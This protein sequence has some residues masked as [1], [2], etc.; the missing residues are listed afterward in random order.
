MEPKS[1]SATALAVAEL[2]MARYKAEHIERT[3]GIANSAASLGS[4]VHGALELFVQEYMKTGV[5]PDIKFLLDMF[6]ISYMTTFGT[7][8]VD[9][10]DFAE[11]EAML[12]A[13]FKRTDWE[14]VTVLSCEVKENFPI[15]TPIGKIP[16]N[17]IWDRFDQLGPAEY[18]VVDYK[19]NKWGIN[20]GDL[21]KKIQARAYGLAAQIKYPQ[22]ERIWVE[23]DMLRHEGPVGIVFTKE[24]NAATWRFLKEKAL[25]IVNTPDNE[26]VE[27]LNPE[28]LFCVRKQTC[29]AVTKNIYV[30]GIMSVGG[31]SEAVDLRATLEYQAKAVA[32][33]IRELDVMI[34]TEAKETDVLQF[35]SDMNVLSIGVSSRRNVDAERVEHVLGPVLFNKYGG[36]SF[37][38]GTVDK[39]LKGDELTDGQ[40]SE[41]RKLVYSKKGEPSVKVAPKNPI[42]GD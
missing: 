42:D 8:D 32:S 14:G 39:L 35:E 16:F 5:L 4:S 15:P 24:E 21:K 17:Y 12:R 18:R 23:F 41:L 9:T 3:R 34:L 13:W 26:V 19:T 29:E 33:A 7:A 10:E 20:P 36:K 22:A 11:G 31:A 1:F 27:T 40:K 2:C 28:C 25:E 38:V 6:R 37:A 30:G